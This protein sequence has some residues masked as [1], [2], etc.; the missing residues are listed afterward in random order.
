MTKNLI[1]LLATIFLIIVLGEWLF[2]KFIEKLPLRLYGLIDKNLRVLAQSSK[3][4]QIPKD[5][6]AITG[7]SYAVGAGDW[8][9]QVLANHFLDSPDYSAAHLIHKKTG[10]DVISFGRGGA[11]SFD[12]IWLEPVTQLLYINSVRDYKL[13]PPKDILIFFYEGND[14]Y[15]NVQFLRHNS[16]AMTTS[17][18]SGLEAINDK[19]PEVIKFKK[20]KEFL[21]AEFEKPLNENLNNNFWENMI[22]MRFLFR[23][24]SNLKKELFPSE[25]KAKESDFSYKLAPEGSVTIAF[26]SGKAVRLNVALMNGKEINLPTKLQAPPQFGLTEF[27]KKEGLTDQLIELSMYVFYESVTRLASFFPQSKINIIY[28]PSPVS[29]YSMVS[30]HIHYSGYMQDIDIGETAIVKKRHKKLCDTIKRFAEFNNF[31]FINTT[32]SLRHAALS[33]FIHGPIDW[34]H[35]NQRGYKV[36]SD[37]LAKLF[38]V[39]KEGARMDNCMYEDSPNKKNVSANL[40]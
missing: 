18:V 8:L 1:L 2:P 29:S 11:G 9:N 31:S 24:I 34:N 21:N 10:I 12:G 25:E 27:Q 35:F 4:N 7:D 28:I 39:K 6:I 36:L 13:S 3:K 16:A 19:K 30:S 26:L 38:L 15:D 17:K 23:G 37:D 32:K 5:Y 33:G 22:F 14:V 20:I 40:K